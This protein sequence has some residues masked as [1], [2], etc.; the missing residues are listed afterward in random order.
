M[1]KRIAILGSTGSVGTQTLEV[2]D[3]HPDHFKVEVLAAGRNVDLLEKQVR[4]YQPKLAVVADQSLADTLATRLAGAQLPTTIMYG[5]DG[6]VQAAGHADSDMVITGIVGSQGLKPTLAAIEAGKTIGLANKETLVSAGH[7][8]MEAARNKGVDIIPVDSEH[9]ALFQSLNG[10]KRSAID[11]LILTASG[12]SFRDRNREELRNVTVADALKHPN[13]SMGAKITI[14][15]ATMAN[16]GLEVIEA[17]W[18]FDIPYE[19]IEVVIH[20]ESIIHSMIQ[21]ADN[22]LIAQMGLPNMTLPIQYAMTYPE[23]MHS[24]A[25]AMDFSKLWTLHFKPMDLDRF[26][27]LR[28]AYESGRAG[29]TATTVFNAA[30]EEAVSLF[31]KEQISFLEIETLIEQVLH[32]HDTVSSPNLEAIM[33]ADTWARQQTIARAARLGQQ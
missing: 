29:G 25:P 19:Q 12:G 8:V 3:Q 15:S 31:L 27:C 24:P 5:A 23:R 21:Y 11:K 20:P 16:K 32:M 22:S 1:T 4:K 33:H 13:W 18:L 28:L 9:S 30:N 14:D 10:E 6:L 7:L 26:P 17:R 2:V